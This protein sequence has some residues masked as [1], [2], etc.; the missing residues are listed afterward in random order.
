MNLDIEFDDFIKQEQENAKKLKLPYNFIVS[1]AEGSVL[2]DTNNKRYID[3]TSN[4]DNNSLGFNNELIKNSIISNNNKLN[5][6][7]SYVYSE[8]VSDLADKIKD[9]SGLNFVYF[10]NSAHEAI[11]TALN[12]LKSWI[13]NNYFAETKNEVLFINGTNN[14]QNID[15]YKI[16]TSRSTRFIHISNILEFQSTYLLDTSTFKNLF[17]KRI[18]AVI[19]NPIG[20]IDGCYIADHEILEII[21][22]FC[23]KYNSL[24]IFDSTS[25]SLG[26]LGK[27]LPYSDIDPDILILSNSLGQGIPLGLAATSHKLDKLKQCYQHSYGTSALAADIACKFI[28]MINFES[29]FDQIKL[30]SEY[31]LSRLNELRDKYLS[32]I[33]IINKGLYYTIEFDFN[34]VELVERCK[35]DGIIVE[36]IDSKIIKLTPPFIITNEEIDILYEV[37]D[38]N[39]NLLKGDYRLK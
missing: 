27:L 7:S 28:N 39:L 25:V 32:I 33:E 24:L 18:A 17:T 10:S 6:L 8:S 37:L 4:L 15:I 19:V 5:Y 2:T 35:D 36:L 20:I 23:E 16:N 3:F 12:L 1:K 9:V 30:K 22:V 21:K 31:L 34:L 38:K 11:D 29:Y 13:E 14:V 26:R